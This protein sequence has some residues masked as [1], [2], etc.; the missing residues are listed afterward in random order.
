MRA[1][2]SQLAALPS[3]LVVLAEADILHDEGQA[4]A[5]RLRQ[6]GVPVVVKVY[7]GTIHGFFTHALSQHE[8]A[9]LDAVGWLKKL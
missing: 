7:A 1:S 3:T 5:A 2:A 9:V 4:Y 8:A 6:Q